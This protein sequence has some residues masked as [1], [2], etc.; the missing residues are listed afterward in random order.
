LTMPAGLWEKPLQVLPHDGDDLGLVHFDLGLALLVGAPL[1]AVRV[2]RILTPTSR[3]TQVSLLLVLVV[4]NRQYSKR[5]LRQ[6]I[7]SFGQRETRGAYCPSTSVTG[8]F[9]VDFWRRSLTISTSRLDSAARLDTDRRLTA[10]A[11]KNLASVSRLK[12]AV[13]RR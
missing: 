7:E 13:M 3:D 10:G 2:S 5:A 6:M 12:L 11:R 4:V 9:L 8:N 1:L